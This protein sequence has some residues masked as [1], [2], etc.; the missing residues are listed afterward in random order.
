[1]HVH[2]LAL[3]KRHGPQRTQGSGGACSG[4]KRLAE[5]I[6]YVW[7]AYP[8][9]KSIAGRF[10]ASTIRSLRMPSS[11][12][13]GRPPGNG[14][15]SGCS[16]LEWLHSRSNSCVCVSSYMFESI[17]VFMCLY[18]CLCFLVRSNT[19]CRYICIVLEEIHCVHIHGW[20]VSTLF[21]SPLL[22]SM[23]LLLLLLLGR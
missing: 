15:V 16:R 6:W 1:M 11:S 22:A 7:W 20:L 2:C 4:I 14:M 5:D 8:L 21:S 12:L 13:Q 19:M 17:Y 3:Y 10:L 9:A 23:L 18:L